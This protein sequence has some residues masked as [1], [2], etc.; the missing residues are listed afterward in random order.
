M[1]SLDVVISLDVVSLFTNI[2]LAIE[3][4]KNKWTFIKNNTNVLF[5]DFMV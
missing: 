2:D 1:V 4:V 3:N 5:D